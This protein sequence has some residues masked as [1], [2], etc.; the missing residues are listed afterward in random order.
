M[1]PQYRIREATLDEREH[2]YND[3]RTQ[4][5]TQKR[6]GTSRETGKKSHPKQRRIL[7]KETTVNS[8]NPSQWRR[9]QSSPTWNNLI[10]TKQRKENILF[11]ALADLLEVECPMC[12]ML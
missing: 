4:E 9:F 2:I 7:E 1:I 8:R 6:R 10:L 11:C 3:R 5:E 12:E